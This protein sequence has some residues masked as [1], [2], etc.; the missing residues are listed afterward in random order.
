MCS[1][2]LGV[3]SGVNLAGFLPVVSVNSGLTA[4]F[5]VGFTLAPRYITGAEVAL[6]LLME[7]I[8]G[9]LWVFLRFGDIPSIWTVRGL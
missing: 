6:I 5:Y 2:D 8:C 7:T 9:P 1:L 3:V 4:A